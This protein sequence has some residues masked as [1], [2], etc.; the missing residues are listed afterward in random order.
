MLVKLRDPADGEL[1]GKWRWAEGSVLQVDFLSNDLVTVDGRTADHGGLIPGFIAWPRLSF[2]VNGE[3][4]ELVSNDEAV[5]KRHYSRPQHQ[6]VAYTS[7]SRPDPYRLGF[8]NARRAQVRR[9][10]HGVQGRVLDVGSGFSLVHGAGPWGF[11]LFACDR[12][13]AAIDYLRSQGVNAVIADVDALPYRDGAFDALYA[14]E[15]IE[16]LRE[17]D[18]ALRSWV[19]A[20]RPGGR[21]VITTPN[22]RHLLARASGVEQVVNPEHLFEYSPAELRAAVVRAGARVERLEGLCLPLPLPFPGRG[23]RDIV[24][25]GANR[26]PVPIS[27]RL[28]TRWFTSTRRLASLSENLCVVA[29]RPE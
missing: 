7:P 14:G 22:R 17:P 2:D 18:Q 13:A 28:L 5:L 24:R 19:R 10:L 9:A 26:S 25:V 8:H 4:V 11:E 1:A 3:T 23:W 12:D 29:T 15:I 16:H 21:V 20:V 6:E 27:D